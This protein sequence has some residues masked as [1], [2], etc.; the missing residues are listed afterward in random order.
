MSS[1]ELPRAPSGRVPRWVVDEAAGQVPSSNGWASPVVVEPVPAPRRRSLWVRLGVVAV[2][3]GLGWW[4]ATA[5]LPGMLQEADAP[6]LDGIVVGRVPEPTPEVAALADEMFLTDEGRD[7][8]YSSRPELL[9]AEEFAGRCAREGDDAAAPTGGAVG[10]YHST[11]GGLQVGGRIVIYQPADARLRGFVV[12]TAAHEL[13]HAAW[14]EL[15]PTERTTVTAALE[16][17]VAGIDPADDL[18]AQL[19]GSVGIHAGNRATELFSYVGTQVWAPGGLDPALEAQYARFV[20]D[21]E[22]LVG[23]HTAFQ[24]QIDTLTSDVN[25]AQEALSQRLFDQQVATA[26]LD[27]DTTRL[28]QYRSTIEQ[29]EARLAALPASERA[30]SLLAWT[31]LDGTPLPEA[32]AS[33]LIA[34]ARALLARDE[35]ALAARA[36]ALRVSGEEITAEETRVAGLRADAEALFAQL[37]P[38]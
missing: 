6:W 37:A 10:C 23:V 33:E 13:L 2:V 9:G 31:W 8:L 5:V 18:H 4:L 16:G 27:A 7:L 3:A 36:E 17:V 25:T 15:S 35:A 26:Q 11:A 22:A 34:S 24:Q 12:E 38:A 29:E 20:T 14:N 19:D 28:A 32:P 21:R 30:R 1:D